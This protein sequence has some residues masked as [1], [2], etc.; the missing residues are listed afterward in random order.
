MGRFDFP[1]PSPCKDCVVTQY[2][3][4]IEYADGSYANAN[5]GTYL[6]H[7]V[8]FNFGRKSATCSAGDLP[9]FTFASGNER[10]VA[11]LSLNG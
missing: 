3:F 7:A 2:T 1:V 5:T 11:S 10:T 6:H 4:G 8:F 9:E